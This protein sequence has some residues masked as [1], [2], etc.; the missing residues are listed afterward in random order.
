MPNLP[1][2]VPVYEP[3][4]PY[5]YTFDNTP[6][7]ALIQRDDIINSQVDINTQVLEVAGGK[8]GDLPTRLNQSLDSYGNLLSLAVNDSMH[9]IGYHVDGIGPDYIQYVR[10]TA[11]ERAK[12]ASVDEN[13]T[14]LAITVQP[15]TVTG[16][17]SPAL[18]AVAFDNGF[19]NFIPS[20]T[21]TWSISDGQKIS[22]NVVAQPDGHIHY[23]N[24]T[25]VSASTTPDYINYLTGISAP[26]ETNSLMVYINGV[27]IF[28][29]NLVYVPTSDPND[30]WV[31]N[32]FTPN[33]TKTGFGL[34]NAI[35]AADV[36]IIDFRI[37]A[38]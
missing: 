19:L 1:N 8:A 14:N 20:D 15:T 4:Q 35:T 16:Y 34:Q 17:S 3:N 21:V 22:A 7:N 38:S 23:D 24:V 10:M 33:V 27:R 2:N 25:P 36:I 26:F 32:K 13:A 28:P 12:L 6:I 18:P 31:Q 29:S 37:S 9:N 30:T 5:Y 11:E